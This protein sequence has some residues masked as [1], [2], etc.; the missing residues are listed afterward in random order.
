M[1]LRIGFVTVWGLPAHGGKGG[2]GG[3]EASLGVL[4]VSVLLNTSSPNADPSA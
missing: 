3:V 2:L 4:H 1:G